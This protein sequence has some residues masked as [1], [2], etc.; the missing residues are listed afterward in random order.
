MVTNYF[1]TIKN[2]ESKTITIL[3]MFDKE[4]EEGLEEIK[5]KGN[6][7]EHAAKL[8]P[9]MEHR[10]YQLQQLESI[11]EYYNIRLEEIEGVIHKSL[12]QDKNRELTA[13]DLKKYCLCDPNY[14]AARR[15]VLEVAD[16]RNKFLSLLKGFDTKNWMIGHITKL[17]TAG[18]DDAEV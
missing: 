14:I 1:E 8:A 7:I 15:M 2:D 18:L 5:L 11:L 4:Y 12:K 17:K 10:Y 16:R 13:N 6:L 3:Q 9:L